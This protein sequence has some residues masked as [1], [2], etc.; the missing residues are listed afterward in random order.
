MGNGDWHTLGD[1]GHAVDR[2]Q[3]S[4]FPVIVDQGSRLLEVDVYAVRYDLGLVVTAVAVSQTIKQRL[5]SDLQV[6]DGVDR[7][8]QL[9]E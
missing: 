9:G 4:L 8:L 3:H 7:P 1:G 2:L 6:E 5:A